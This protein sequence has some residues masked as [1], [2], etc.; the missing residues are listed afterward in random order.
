MR[1]LVPKVQV[2]R[3]ATT[4]YEKAILCSCS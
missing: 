3:P 4:T 1:K 2:A